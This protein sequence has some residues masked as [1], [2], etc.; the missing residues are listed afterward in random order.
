[1]GEEAR[2]A[3]EH[4]LGSEFEGMRRLWELDRQWVATQK[5]SRQLKIQPPARRLADVETFLDRH[6]IAYV[7]LRDRGGWK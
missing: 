2:A 6:F 4:L 7:E 3:F 5:M 1:M